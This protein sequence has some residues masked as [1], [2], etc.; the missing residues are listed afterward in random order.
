M[1]CSQTLGFTVQMLLPE[2]HAPR[3]S[4]GVV[5]AAVQ[6]YQSGVGLS[7]I[8][9]VTPG[10]VLHDAVLLIDQNHEALQ[11]PAALEFGWGGDALIGHVSG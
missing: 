8:T 7:L 9:K 6:Q 2:E 11:R 10:T 5:A 3:L 1:C 4:R